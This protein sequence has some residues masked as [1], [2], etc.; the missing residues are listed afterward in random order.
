MSLGDLWNLLFKKLRIPLVH[1]SFQRHFLLPQLCRSHIFALCFWINGKFL[2][3]RWNNNKSNSFKDKD[4]TLF[5]RRNTARNLICFMREQYTSSN[6]KSFCTR[7]E[8]IVFCY[9]QSNDVCL[10]KYS[11]YILIFLRMYQRIA[12]CPSSLLQ[13]T[14]YCKTYTY[15]FPRVKKRGIFTAFLMRIHSFWL[16]CLS[17]RWK[18]DENQTPD[19]K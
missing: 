12:W 10:S 3:Y 7:V 11:F 8:L 5:V 13:W 6:L 18:S 1:Q 9:Y 2:F 4:G 19:Q 14:I 16:F 15:H 17:K